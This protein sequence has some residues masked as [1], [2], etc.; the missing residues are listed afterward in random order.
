MSI[1]TSGCLI[2]G[3]PYTEIREKLEPRAKIIDAMIDNGKLDYCSPY[4]DSGLEDWVV[5][6]IIAESEEV[7]D[8]DIKIT[9]AKDWFLKE[10][11]LPAKIYVGPNIC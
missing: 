5:G 9:T 7:L 4:Y 3:L 11:G 2:V 8:L 6:K 10:F 1:Q